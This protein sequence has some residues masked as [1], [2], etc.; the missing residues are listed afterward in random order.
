MAAGVYNFEVEQGASKSFSVNLKDSLGVAI[1]L[2]G[3]SGRGQIKIKAS[4]AVPLAE[5]VV[6]VTDPANGGVTVSLP[7]AALSGHVSIK[8]AS[9]SAKVPAV[10][11]VELYTDDDE[12]VIRLLNGAVQI[13]PEVTR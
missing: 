13:S 8:G 5:L 7:A 6:E 10:Y 2:T 9:Y 4:D 11:D 1:D 3:Y 12:D